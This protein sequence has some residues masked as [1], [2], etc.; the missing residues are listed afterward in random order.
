MNSSSP[1]EPREGDELADLSPLEREAAQWILRREQGL[2]AA[3]ERVFD[4]WLKAD[5]AHGRMIVEMEETSRLLGVLGKETSPSLQDFPA[6]ETDSVA[7]QAGSRNWRW[8]LGLAACAA[9]AAG[10]VLWQRPVPAASAPSFAESA[11]TEIGGLRHMTLPDG[12]VIHLNTDTSVEVAFAADV[13]RIKLLRGEA[14]FSVAKDKARPFWVEAGPIAVRAVGTEFNVRMQQSSVDVLVAEG[15]VRVVQPQ[16]GQSAETIAPAAVLSVG[17]LANVLV[18]SISQS[19]VGA[20]KVSSIDAQ[21]MKRTLAWRDGGLQFVDTPLAQVV[22]EF[23]RYNQRQIVIEDAALGARRFGG[24]FAS[25]QTEPLLELL[26]Q[27]FGV[28]TESRNGQIVIRV[29]K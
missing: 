13:R 28:V 7:A 27:S 5:P 17:Q 25:H 11:K 26:E 10:V 4:E 20:V 2:T 21:A 29:A 24:A 18:G 22:A 15:V 16:P 9:L 12:S 6:N 14:L 23:N 3:D 1:L 19:P 8:M